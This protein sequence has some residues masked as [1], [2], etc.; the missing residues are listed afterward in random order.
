MNVALVSSSRM[1]APGHLQP[2]LGDD[3]GGLDV[4]RDP[5]PAV[6]HV[7]WFSTL[8]R[9]PRKSTVSGGASL[10]TMKPSLR[11][12][13]VGRK[14][15][16]RLRPREREPAD[17]ERQRGLRLVG[18]ARVVPE[19]AEPPLPIRSIAAPGWPSRPDSPSGASHTAPRKPSWNGSM[20]TSSATCSPAPTT[21]GT[22]KLLSAAI[23]FITSAPPR[24][25][26]R[27]EYQ[28]WAGHL[29]PAPTAIGVMPASFSV[30]TS[31]SSSLHVAGGASM[32]ACSK[33][34]CCTRCR[35]CSG[36]TAA[37][38]GRRRC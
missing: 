23:W 4:R 38:T 19:G 5:A 18:E 28:K 7:R 30:W 25:T 9:N 11:A 1:S 6:A 29:S 32:P 36:C 12:E 16:L 15:R 34:S 24:R 13:G 14:L 22:L 2:E 26:I 35:R 17:L 20:A 8:V 31:S 10:P 27:Y 37:R 21:A 33:R 3:G